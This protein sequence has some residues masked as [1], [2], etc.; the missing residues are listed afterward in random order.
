MNGNRTHTKYQVGIF[1]EQRE[2]GTYAIC[3]VVGGNSVHVATLHQL[4]IARDERGAEILGSGGWKIV[5]LVPGRRGSRKRYSTPRAAVQ[6]MFGK[7]IR[8]HY[9]TEVR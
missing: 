7:A 8:F 5:W 1:A 3:R 4:Q 6:A 9:L 2:N